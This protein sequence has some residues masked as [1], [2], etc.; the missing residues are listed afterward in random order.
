MDAGVTQPFDV[1]ELAFDVTLVMAGADEPAPAPPT[2]VTP[3]PQP[4]QP[5][6]ITG[7]APAG[8]IAPALAAG[9]IVLLGILLARRRRCGRCDRIIARDDDWVRVH[10][11]PGT[12]L[13]RTERL[14]AECARD[15]VN[16]GTP[17]D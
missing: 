11:A 2:P 4:E 7:L 6:A 13:P 9:A 17:A 15:R 1:T 3:A 14:C 8:V 16:G 5:L 10:N 12:D